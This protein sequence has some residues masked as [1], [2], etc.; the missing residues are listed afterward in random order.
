VQDLQQKDMMQLSFIVKIYEIQ[1]RLLVQFSCFQMEQVFVSLT[2]IRRFAKN[3]N[4]LSCENN[5]MLD[6]DY[7]QT[8]NPEKL[9]TTSFLL[10]NETIHRKL[11]EFFMFFGLVML[12]LRLLTLQ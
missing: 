2:Q 11:L 1:L 7:Y 3:S 5:K 6:D 4:F 8:L 12:S 9:V 10:D